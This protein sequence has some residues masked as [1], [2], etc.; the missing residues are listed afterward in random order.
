[1]S[2]TFIGLAGHAGAGKDY[3]Y[4]YLR[5][6]SSKEVHRIA[7]A[8]GV[9][10]E[11]EATLTEGLT[12]TQGDGTFFELDELP[13]LWRKPYPTE[14][15][16][17]LQWWGTELR[18]SQD[19]DYWVTRGIERAYEVVNID[20]TYRRSS[21]IVFTDVRFENEAKAIDERGGIVL[22]VI[23]REEVRARRLGGA[24]PPAHASEE[25]DFRDYLNGHILNHDDGR[26]PFFQT[27]FLDLLGL[28]LP[29]LI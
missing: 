28:S 13:A 9:R 18:R 2:H 3:V 11:V 4:E 26:D 27:H 10:F 21:L 15:R 12:F 7:F 23:A 16:R 20:E 29:E 19:P 25:I 8:D 6:H 24:L 14:I 22:E 1:M 17:L 5:K